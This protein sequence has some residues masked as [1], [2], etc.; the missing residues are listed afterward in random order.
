MIVIPLTLAEIRWQ[1]QTADKD[2]S[3]FRKY[4]IE[5][6]TSTGIRRGLMPEELLLD[7]S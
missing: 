5:P 6:F 7:F 4:F 3:K 2:Q 1:S